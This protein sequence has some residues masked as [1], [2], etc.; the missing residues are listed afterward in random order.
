[1]LRIRFS[2]LAFCSLLT[3]MLLT[4]ANGQETS[5]EKVV[6]KTYAKLAYAVQLETIHKLLR[7]NKHATLSDLENRLGVSAVKFGLSSFSSGSVTD[8]AQQAYLDFV[9]KPN[10]EDVLSVGPG[11]FRFT[12]DLADK[13]EVRETKENTAQ[14]RWSKGQN[15]TGEDWTIPFG[16]ALPMIEAQN[17]STYSR[18]AAYKVTV[19]FEGRSRSY[20]AMFLFGTGEE[21][22]LPLDNVTINS[23][24]VFFV[25][26]S[27]YPAVLLETPVSQKDSVADW[28]KAHQVSDAECRSGQREVC[29]DLDSLSCGVAAGDV[30]FMLTKPI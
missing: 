10:G 9:T 25:K 3:L 29:C 15:L 18:Y 27:V 12:E 14:A 6:R 8:I 20:N 26:N 5:E 24:L 23:A 4:G 13:R 30:A 19:V 7:E 16:Q 22:V 11:T 1:M 21:P 17:K 28:L 2:A